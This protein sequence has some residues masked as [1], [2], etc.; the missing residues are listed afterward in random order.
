MAESAFRQTNEPD[1]EEEDY[2][3]D[4]S[5][6]LPPEDTSS[7]KSM[8]KKV[9]TDGF[10]RVLQLIFELSNGFSVS[11]HLNSRVRYPIHFKFFLDL[12]GNFDFRFLL[13]KPLLFNHRIRNPKPSIGKNSEDGIE[14][15]SNSKRMNR[16]WPE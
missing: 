5:K 9:T 2:M 6:L 14:N 16:H 7:S 1:D 4:L 3:G 15:G 12:E 10:A 13:I 11:F 8:S